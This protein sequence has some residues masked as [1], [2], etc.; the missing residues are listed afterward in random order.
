[1]S[2]ISKLI[3][4]GANHYVTSPFGY[5]KA[6]ST[7]GGTTSTYHSGTDYGTDNK[8][9]PQY[10]IEDGYVFA[11]DKASDGALYVWV[12]Y[13]RVKLALLHYHLDS[14][15]V[16]AGQTVKKGTLLGYTGKTGKATG[17]HLHL[18][19]RKLN[20]LTDAQIKS[21]TWDNLRKCDYTDPEKVSYTAPSDFLP[22]RGYFTKGDKSDNVGK[23][24][25][26]LA[27]KAKGN[28]YGDYLIALVKVFQEKNGIYPDGDVGAK[29]LP[30]L[31]KDGFKK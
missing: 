13:P 1:M 29:T 21:M 24:A 26:Y 2:A 20:E 18:G 22:S 19:I 12:I 9:I 28:L 27:G 7:S 16:K 31:E 30:A 10:A 6:I 3:F 17:I 8:K 15:K 11:A 4:N 23:L 5:R 25:D 14:Y